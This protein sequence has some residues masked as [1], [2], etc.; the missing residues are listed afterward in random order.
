MSLVRAERIMNRPA[1][2][3]QTSMTVAKKTRI[4]APVFGR[5]FP[6]PDD[7]L[8]SLAAFPAECSESKLA[9]RSREGSSSK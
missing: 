4:R 7:P 8:E 5:G 2:T 6:I 1:M 3:R 9:S